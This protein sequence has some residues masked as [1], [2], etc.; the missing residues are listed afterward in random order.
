VTTPAARR[1]ASGPPP[2]QVRVP[3]KWERQTAILDLVEGRAIRTQEELVE[4]LRARGLEVTQATVSRDLRELGLARV[5]GGEGPRY[6]AA[7]L[8]T[9]GAAVTRLRAALRDHVRSIEF[10]DVLG[11]VRTRPSSA[12]LVAAAIDGARYEEVA[13]TV[14]GDDTVLVVTRG[15][16]A[17]AVLGSRLRA[18]LGRRGGA[19]AP[20]AT[21]EEVSP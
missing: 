3:G 15:R 10:V 13:G 14:A 4:G 11:V 2:A 18:A 1:G 5:A 12:P 17:A 8:E 20:G 21:S 6:V 7:V 19:P 9:E 16:Q